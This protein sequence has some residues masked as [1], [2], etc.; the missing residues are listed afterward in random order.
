MRACDRMMMIGPKRSIGRWDLNFDPLFVAW[1]IRFS[2]WRIHTYRSYVKTNFLGN[3]WT[4]QGSVGIFREQSVQMSQSLTGLR[5]CRDRKY[6]QILIERICMCYY[7]LREAVACVNDVEFWS[8]LRGLCFVVRVLSLQASLVRRSQI[9]LVALYDCTRSA[10]NVEEL[11][12]G[13]ILTRN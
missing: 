5:L 8:R 9:G 2:V 1:H 11:L 13:L 6:W 7:A 3:I 10:S 4:L 12:N